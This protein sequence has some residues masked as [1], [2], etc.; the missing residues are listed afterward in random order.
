M[1]AGASS[2]TVL[3]FTV[4]LGLPIVTTIVTSLLVRVAVEVAPSHLM[5][6]FATPKAFARNLTG[7]SVRFLGVG[8]MDKT[9]FRKDKGAIDVEL[10]RIKR[11]FDMGGFIPC[12]DHRLMPGSK[13]EL[14][15]YYAEEIK[16]IRI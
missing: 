1:I 15:Q 10:E 2:A 16:K 9:A 5:P 13:I 14:V 8:G 7:R 3:P 4:I 6:S 12:P 11:L